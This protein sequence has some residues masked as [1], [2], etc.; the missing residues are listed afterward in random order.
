MRKASE[1][2]SNKRRGWSYSIRSIVLLSAMVTLF[3]LLLAACGSDPTPT[4]RP[5]ATAVPVAAAAPTA[6]PD[7]YQ[8]YIDQLIAGAKAEGGRLKIFSAHT[9]EPGVLNEEEL[10]VRKY[11]W[12]QVEM[13]KEGSNSRLTERMLLEINAG[14]VP[15]IAGLGGSHLAQLR[16]LHH[17]ALYESPIETMGLYRDE[18]TS[19]THYSV[20]VQLRTLHTIY[21]SSLVDA[22][23]LGPDYDTWLDEKYRQQIGIDVGG[24]FWQWWTAMEKRYGIAEADEFMKKFADFEPKPF[25]SNNQIRN[26]VAAGEL[27][28]GA[29][30]Y[31][32]NILI[33]QATGAPVKMWNADPEPFTI[34]GFGILARG[35]HPNAARLFIEHRLSPE[36]QAE[37]SETTL[38][39]PIRKDVPTAHA[40]YFQGDFVVISDEDVDLA[41]ERQR[42]TYE[43]Y[44]RLSPP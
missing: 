13:I 27:M 41:S 35:E 7:P 14:R 20:P 38:A 9:E 18:Y 21:N 6:T 11:P 39:V 30:I 2:G 8:E 33:T 44:F 42:A 12:M 32:D 19:K 37:R 5:T 4:P 22:S 26:L 3:A 29:Y 16:D 31:L 23:A 40:E 17:L 10:F 24:T 25:W 15:D 36:V 34:G 1:S 43:K 28:F